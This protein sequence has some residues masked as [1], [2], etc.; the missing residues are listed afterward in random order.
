MPDLFKPGD[1]DYVQKLN[2]LWQQFQLAGNPVNPVFSTF[3]GSWAIPDTRPGKKQPQD[4]KNYASVIEF[5][6]AANFDNPPGSAVG[7]AYVMTVAGFTSSGVGGGGTPV[8]LSF[9]DVMGVRRAVSATSWGPWKRVASYDDVTAVFGSPSS[10]GQCLVVSGDNVSR[11]T[12]VLVHTGG[13]T[14]IGL[15]N[16]SALVGGQFDNTPYLYAGSQIETNSG[17]NFGSIVQVKGGQECIRLKD[18]NAFISFWNSAVT[19]RMGYIQANAG[20]TLDIAA[21]T[22]HALRFLTNSTAKV[23]IDLNG[24]QYPNYD[25]VQYLGIASN[26]YAAIFSRTGSIQTSDARKKTAVKPMT[27]AMRAAAREMLDCI[28][29]YQWLDA[30]KDKGSDKARWHVGFTVQQ[31]IAILEKHK[32]DPFSLAFICHDEWPAEYEN[33]QINVGQKVT[34]HHDVQRQKTIEHEHVEDVIEVV[35]GKP[36]LVTK[37]VKTKELVFVEMPVTRPDGSPVML[38]GDKPATVR[39]P[40][41]ET[42]SDPYEAD[43][44][45]V[46]E[47]V[48]IREAGEGYSFR[49]DQLA[50]FILAGLKPN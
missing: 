29:T 4:Y 17:M 14:V 12:A 49:Y 9:G 27:D 31:A 45:P 30:I 32:I 1:R 8:Q 34:K 47:K 48:L 28:G 50:L 16:K 21:D 24:N 33:R 10:V 35:D 41:M 36:V 40:V 44:D 46:Y 18:N 23:I 7:Y 43:A 2:Q 3:G 6:D 38:D 42:V 19:A 13:S 26:A 25:N 5:N 20:S 15:G 11:G 37:P 22:G 39:M